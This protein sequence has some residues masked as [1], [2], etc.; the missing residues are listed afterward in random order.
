MVDFDSAVLERSR[1]VPV[2]VDFWADWCGPCHAL[3]PIIEGL[4]AEAGGRWELVKI[5][6]EEQP[7][8][9]G[10]FGVSSIPA[11]KMFHDGEI[12]AEFVGALPAAEIRRWL[13]ENLP[14]PRMA[15][16]SDIVAG[17]ESRGPEIAAELEAFLTD[18]PDV[19][20]A[21]LRLAQALVGRDP[22]RARQLAGEFD[23]GSD[24]AE[25]A[26]DVTALA[27][28][29][30]CGG[31]LPPRLAPHVEGAKSSLAAHDLGGTLEHLVDLAMRDRGFGDELAR[32]ASVALFDLLGHDHE[33]TREHRRRLAMALH[34]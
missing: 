15:R 7:G 20:A 22:A 27:D 10:D 18:H 3:G 6:V 5:D 31:D 23:E 21:R 4:A 24:L 30:E 32:R 19:P 28:L 14:D 26:A 11:V 16:L 12:V 33:L 25:L 8:P 9:A 2:V 17:W 34:S 29:M 1:T 13:D